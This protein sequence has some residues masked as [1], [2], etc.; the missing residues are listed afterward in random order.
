MAGRPPW[1]ASRPR[2]NIRTASAPSPPASASSPTATPQR[3]R[4]PCTRRWRRSSSSRSRARR[5]SSSPPAGYLPRLRE[6]T[7]RHGALLVLDEIQSGLGR[8]GRLFAYEHEGIRPDVV[9]VGKALG[10]GVYPVSG[11]LADAPVMD[12]LHPGDHGSTFGGNPAAAAVARAALAVLVEEKMVERSAEL[13]AYF[14][15]RLSEVG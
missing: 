1:S 9:I 7:A 12:V 4:R 15:A 3:S 8:T 5:G 13:G 11:I 6:I 2:P 14:M 10:G